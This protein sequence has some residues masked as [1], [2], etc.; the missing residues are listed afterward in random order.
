M[1]HDTMI[2]PKGGLS[3]S[4]LVT[5][6]LNNTEL[7]VQFEMTCALWHDSLSLQDGWITGIKEV[8]VVSNNT[9]TSCDI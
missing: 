5:G 1:M 6:P 4:V 3:D 7:I 9:Q 2:D 8:H